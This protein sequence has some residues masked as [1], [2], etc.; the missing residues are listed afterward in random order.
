M[1][2]ENIIEYENK[3]TFNFKG[4]INT[5]KKLLDIII[6]R[7]PTMA[8]DIVEIETNTSS[9]QDEILTQRLALTPIFKSKSDLEKYSFFDK[10]ECSIDDE[11]NKCEK[12]SIEF[13]LD[14]SNS[15][16]DDLY[17]LSDNLTPKNMLIKSI[18]IC[19]LPS[20][21]KI[22]D[23]N[24]IK[25]KAYAKKGIGS[26]NS[27]WSA[28]GTSWYSINENGTFLFTV[29]P[30]GSLKGRDILDIAKEILKNE[31]N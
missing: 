22:K 10:C 24:K 4:K 29:E 6:G 8:I 27:K 28:V 26:V 12:C 18:I 2:F 20:N 3:I 1:E 14:F 15:G 31:L 19:I 30:V 21:S 25:L 16:E 13:F 11:L 5:A 17:I 9:T 7:I 23:K